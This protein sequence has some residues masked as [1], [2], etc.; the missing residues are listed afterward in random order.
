M[1]FRKLTMA[2]VAVVSLTFM[3]APAQAVPIIGTAE[4]TFSGT[5]AVPTDPIQIGST[6]TSTLAFWGGTTGDFT[7]VTI[8]TAIN[9]PF[10][11]TASVGSMVAFASGVGN[12]MGTVGDVTSSA[13]NNQ[14]SVTTFVLVGTFTP[15]G[16]LAGLGFT[17]TEARLVLAATQSQGDN[18]AGGASAVSLSGT[19]STVP[20]PVPASLALLGAG[21]VAL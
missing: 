13:N 19:L 18:G 8:G 7:N 6:F 9:T 4:I 21:L 1:S 3:G 12:F 2:A 11:F 14:E 17:E 10:S 5:S 15:L 16:T 20:V